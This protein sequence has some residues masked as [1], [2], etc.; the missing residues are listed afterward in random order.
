M[1]YCQPRFAK[2]GGFLLPRSEMNRRIDR[3]RAVLEHEQIDALLV[4]SD[5]NR[6]YLSGFTGSAGNLIVTAR[7]ALLLSDFRYEAQAAVEAPDFEFRL[8]KPAET[9]VPGT[10]AAVASELKLSI[11]GFEAAH[12]T[13]AEHLAL[14]AAFDEHGS[15]AELRATQGLVEELRVV[16]DAGE[17]ATLERAVAI[18]DAAFAA[19][20]PR[21]RPEMRERDAAWEL[22]KAM[23]EGGAEALAFSIIVAAGPNGTRPHARAGDD[24]LGVGRPIVM[25]FG[26]RLDGYHADMTRTVILGEVDE[27][28]TRIYNLVLDAQQHAVREMRAGMPGKQADALARDRIEAAGHADHFGHGLGHGVGLM[29]HEGPSLR[30]S[31]EEPLPAGAVFSVEPGVY[32]PDWGGVRIED[33]V[34]L[35]DDGARALTRSSKDPLIV[36]E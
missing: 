24:L 32:L 34:V 19:I 4:T 22:E 20:A 29:I 8:V 21:L 12:L 5:A 30:K 23:R 26:A 11:L 15:R 35:G 9:P 6:R 13:V 14:L 28:F 18:T 27:Q 33:L 7:Q 3:L 2:N 31:T 17:L 16:K 25:D 36:L 10:L 1:V